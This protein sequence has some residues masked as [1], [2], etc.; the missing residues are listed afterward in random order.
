MK[1]EEKVHS[2]AIY[3][4][5]S[6][7]DTDKEKGDDSQS[8]ANQKSM[9]KAYCKERDWD[10]YDIYC[11]DGYSGT[12]KDRPNFK[13]MLKDCEKSKVDIVLCKDLS[14]FSRDSTV[15][16]QIV[17][18]KF[19]DWGI[20][21]IGV[22]DNS[23]NDI[24]DNNGMRLF[25]GAFNEFYV[26]DISRKIRK[27]MEHKRRQGEFTGSF[28]PYGYKINPDNRHQ[29]VIDEEVADIVREIFQ[30]Y[31]DGEG[32]RA[33]LKALNDRGVLSPTAYKESKG[34]K[35]ICANLNKSNT[36]GLWT[37][38]T[39]ERMLKN[40]TYIGTLVQGKSHPI[41]YKNKKRK[42]VPKEDWIRCYN[43]HEAII[44]SELWERVQSRINGRL[45]AD[46][47]TQTLSPLSG[48]VKC[49]V[50]GRPMK[51]DI[52]WNKKHTIKYYS[53]Q[54]ASYKIGAMNCT[55]IHNMSGLQLE[56]T[57]L[58]ELNSM[59]GAYCDSENINIEDIKTSK[60]AVLQKR[61]DTLNGKKKK[62]LSRLDGIYTDKLDGLISTNDYIRYKEKFDLEIID[63][64]NQCA[65]LTTSINKYEQSESDIDK[66][67]ELI[68]KYTNV[69][70][71]TKSIVDEF[72]DM[73]YIGDRSE[74]GERDILIEWSV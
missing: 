16:D 52:Y 4:R 22:S 1:G 71:L 7:E 32:Y 48:K 47:I 31:A 26:Q 39:V 34:S 29:L 13:R 60:I 62:I 64:D 65:E 56:Q 21:F 50:C 6:I 45:R 42:P 35:Y 28:A 70:E 20:R 63:I 72:I 55:N 51:R 25:V 49:A 12:N 36:K 24:E 14:R 30:R 18:D 68:S 43:A 69:K 23:S 8:I 54:C 44:P 73:V 17:Y 74:N 9:L 38:S 67:I 3:V 53:L 61:L 57:I 27:T 46:K 37:F 33:I 15:V 11:D 10:I 41:S 19:I 40:E 59:I 58:K 66:K 5:I 2:V